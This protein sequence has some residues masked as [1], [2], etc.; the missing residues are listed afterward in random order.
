MRRTFRFVLRGS[1]GLISGAQAVSWAVGVDI[2]GTN[3]RVA[4]V[5]SDGTVGRMLREP[6]DAGRGG[7]RP[8][9]Q[10]ADMISELL[11]LAAPEPPA[12]IGIGATGPVLPEEGAISNEHTLPKPY[13][14]PVTEI[15]SQKFGVP[16]RLENDADAAAAGESWTGSG[17]DTGILAAVTVGTGVGCGVIRDGKIFRGANGWHPEFGHLVIDP[18]GPLC[19]CG[20][21]G[22]VESI[23]AAPAVA[24]AAVEAG[25]LPDGAQA[26]DVFGA[27]EYDA[28]CRAIVTRAHS[29][30]ATLVINLVATHAPGT[31]VLTG[32]GIGRSDDL[33]AVIRQ[34]LDDYLFTPPGGVTVRMSELR[35]T[36]GC[37][38]AARLML[39]PGLWS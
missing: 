2:G 31:V 34:R 6:L 16:V 39:E 36:A 11:E 29:A 8:L 25:A 27:A 1:A 24:R 14:G 15:L 10:L 21:H 38:G 3:V 13:R 4:D 12:G 19:Y 35:D 7:G 5:T 20:S 33:V 28:S 37:L 22:C 32:N 30:I 9:G 18:S 17:P 26:A 23:A